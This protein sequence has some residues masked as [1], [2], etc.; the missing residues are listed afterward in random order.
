MSKI[1]QL[2]VSVMCAV[3]CSASFAQ[4]CKY[5][6]APGWNQSVREVVADCAV[7][8]PSPNNRLVLKFASNGRMS[9]KGKT[10]RLNGRR[11]EPPAMFSWSPN[12]N[13]FFVND[14]E[15]SGMTSTFRLFRIKGPQIYEDKAVARAAVSLY[16]RRI[17]CNRSAL[18]PDVWGFGWGEGGR[19]IYLLVQATVHQPCGSPY[20]LMSLVVRVSDGKIMESLSPDQ[21]KDRFGSLLPSSLFTK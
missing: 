9:I 18:D 16:R 5:S 12:S 13:G 7:E 14:G 17:N 4:G 3:F 10:I 2:L 20:Q 21:T 6:G 1:I 11:I 19:E 15:G 8:F